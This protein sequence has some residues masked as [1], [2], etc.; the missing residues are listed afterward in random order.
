MNTEQTNKLLNSFRQGLQPIDNR[1]MWDWLADKVELPN[2]YQPCGKFNIDFYPY[3]KRPM[4]DLINDNVKQVN[5]ASCTQAGK[6][7]LQQLYIPYLILESPGPILMVHDTAEN[8]KKCVEERIIP[9]LKNNKDTKRLLDSQRFSA[10]KSG[11]QLPHMTF[12]VTGPAESNILGYSARIILGDEV[13][14]WEANYHKG[15]LQKLQNRQTAY[16]AT[17]KILLTSQPDYECSEWHNECMKGLWYEYGFRCPHCQVLQRY[18]WNDKTEDDKDFGMIMDKTEKDI[19]DMPDYDKKSSSSR[20]VCSHCLKSIYDTAQTRKEL[21]IN[22]DYILIHKG[23]NESIHTYSWPQYVNRSV[24]FKDIAL[25]YLDA[26]SYKRNTGLTD[27]HEVFYQQTLGQFWKPQQQIEQR[28]LI[29]EAYST[30]DLWPDETIRFLVMDPQKDYINW[31]IRAF[32]NTKSESRLID[33]G[34]IIGFSEVEDI[35]KKYN[36]HPLSV[37][38]DSGYDGRNIYAESIQRGKVITL[39]NKQRVFAQ[40][41]CLRGDGGNSPVSPKKFY[42]HRINENGKIVEL[43]KLYSMETYVDPQMPANS[44]YKSFRAKLYSWSNYSI[45]TILIGLRD[46]KLPFDWKINQRG[47]GEYN[48][49]MFS[50]ALNPKT[51]RYEQINGVPN[52]IF[53]MECM[54]LVCGLMSGCFIPAASSLE[55]I[56]KSPELS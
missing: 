29:T 53:D 55:E 23:K 8:A 48:Q 26:V 39:P 1:Q 16:N 44:V 4:E 32:S 5:L 11:V 30:S 36:I 50:E 22:G 34:T 20:L 13:W 6:S 41:I 51:G 19:N 12:R 25:R 2:V 54:A 37:A 42:K 46:H 33:F 40:W 27:K 17:R 15:I 49:Q 38:V 35:M 9:L 56:S 45:K 3:L 28:Q 7:L 43:E 24:T 47:T 14:Q 10:R 31:L 21:V 52:H 18:V